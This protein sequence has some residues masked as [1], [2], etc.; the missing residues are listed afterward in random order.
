M[1]RGEWLRTVSGRRFYPGDPQPDEIDI[2]DIA[3]ALSRVCRFGG[4]IEDHYSV[5]QHSVL[6]SEAVE[7]SLGASLPHPMICVWGLLH[8]A[9]EA[10]LGDVVWPLKR[11]PELAG[12]KVVE[13]RVMR[14]VC[15]RFSLPFDEPELVK[16][17]D[18]RL[19]ATEKRDLIGSGSASKEAGAARDRT[20]PWHSD[21][22]KPLAT[23]IMPWAASVAKQE[24]L[25]RFRELEALR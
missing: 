20:G 24:F 19:L 3:H 12:Y 1:S 25:R 9:S 18:L 13:A 8:D 2:E 11:Q 17:C 22:V 15:Q 23:R 4:H 5:A 14:T 10:Y 7:A 16:A 21:I 6:V